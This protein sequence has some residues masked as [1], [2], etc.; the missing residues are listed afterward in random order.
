MDKTDDL[1]TRSVEEILPSKDGLLNLIKGK[2]IRVYLGVD[3]TG[4]K[5]HLGHTIPLRKLQAFANLGH[6]A[7]LLIGNGTV[8]AG[9]PSQRD[10]A[11]SKITQEQIEENI[12][13]W[14]EQAG[15]V[16]D[17]DKV[18]IKY[19]ADWLLK[20][21]VPDIIEIASNI[22]AVQLFKRAMFTRRLAAGNTVMYHETFYP[23]LQGYDS[24]AM[25]VDL[26]IGGSDQT[27]NMLIGR[28]L[29]KK[30]NNRNKY[31]LTTT[32]INGTDGQ[33]MTKT[34]GN[35]I[36][37]TD[38]PEEMF[39]KIMSISDSEIASYWTNL[40]DL[41]LQALTKLK[42]LEAKKKLALEIV[43]MYHSKNDADKA[44]NRFEAIFQRRERPE[45]IDLTV[46]EGSSLENALVEAGIV[47]SKS[48]AKRLVAQGGVDVDEVK[49][50]DANTK[51]KSGQ[52]VKAGK[53]TYIKVK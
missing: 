3:P 7:I 40:T 30:M 18:E 52:V 21:T 28:E 23:L 26:E 24:V 6:E 49:V 43:S 2:K 17:L 32:L 36:W 46:K 27:F 48:K 29:Q 22:S 19:N 13:T 1:L 11:R 9:D 44:Q 53:K 34:T 16:V 33:Q 37:L 4:T 14:K 25:D 12:K 31:V 20:L 10:K 5:L 41:D 38:T 35:C 8:L 42:P 45:E 51:L 50:T 47:D 39:G 15:K